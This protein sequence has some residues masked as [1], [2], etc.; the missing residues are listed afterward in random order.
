MRESADLAL[1]VGVRRRAFERCGE[2]DRDEA[3]VGGATGRPKGEAVSGR[4]QSLGEAVLA[5]VEGKLY[6]PGFAV[7]RVVGAPR[8]GFGP[9][10]AR[11]LVQIRGLG[12]PPFVIS[13]LARPNC[14]VND[15]RDRPPGRNRLLDGDALLVERL[16]RATSY[17]LQ[18][19][20]ALPPLAISV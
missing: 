6:E 2:N 20:K 1:Q 19:P 11:F 16:R 17:T 4:L 13:T 8:S 15:G 3:E 10:F 12:A 7:V 14:R 5:G 9:P 18:S